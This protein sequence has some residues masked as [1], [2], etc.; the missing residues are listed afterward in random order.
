MEKINEIF[1]SEGPMIAIAKQKKSY[2]LMIKKRN[3]NEYSYFSLN[4][5]LLKLYFNGEITLRE[6]L[7]SFE[8]FV[9]ID[10]YY[11][12]EKN[13]GMLADGSHD[14]LNNI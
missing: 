6:L 4:K 14:I 7:P 12:D 5:E 9:F 2:F 13:R 10:D 1:N 3:C 11:N 8:S